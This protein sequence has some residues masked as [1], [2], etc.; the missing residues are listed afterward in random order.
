MPVEVALL[1]DQHAGKMLIKYVGRPSPWKGK[2][3]YN[4]ACSL[5]NR[6][7]G[8]VVIRWSLANRYPEKC[9]YRLTKVE[10]DTTDPVNF[11]NIHQ[12]RT[13]VCPD[14]VMNYGT[15]NVL[16]FF[17]EKVRNL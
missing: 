5:K 6:G 1:N 8:R 10:P 15:L 9:Y 4:I 11:Q 7:E 14:F 12:I 17:S 16:F 2:T 13:S 3:L